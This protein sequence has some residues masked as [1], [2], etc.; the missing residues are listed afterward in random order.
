MQQR[1]ALTSDLQSAA[2]D[3]VDGSQTDRSMTQDLRARRRQWM[4]DDL[5]RVA[6][7]LFLDRGYDA[8]SVEEVAAAA[9]MSERSFFR[10]FPSKEAVLRRYR[11]SLSARLLRSF[12]ARPS[13]ESPLVALRGAYVESSHVPEAERPRVH[14]LERLLATTDIWAKDLGETVADTSVVAE[15]ARRMDIAVEDLRPA[16]LAAAVSAAAA[17]GWN[18]WARSGGEDDP[19]TMVAAAIDL[20][21]LSD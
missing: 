20:L 6:V 21:G 11:R 14:A 2:V 12:E 16:V 19:S 8:V 7:R 18:S 17:T 3:P 9:G 15:L 4:Q 1:D 13:D 10:Y 5:A